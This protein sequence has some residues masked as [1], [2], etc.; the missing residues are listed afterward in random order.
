MPPPL[1]TNS[2]APTAPHPAPSGPPSPRGRRI[3]DRSAA[4]CKVQPYTPSE[5]R[6]RGPPPPTRRE[7]YAP[8]GVFPEFGA[9]GHAAA[10]T[11]EIGGASRPSSVMA[12]AMTPSPRGRLAP[13]RFLRM[14]LKRIG[15]CRRP[16]SALPGGVILLSAPRSGRPPSVSPPRSAVSAGKTAHSSTANP[17]KWHLPPIWGAG[18]ETPG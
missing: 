16:Y 8:P 3:P 10:P 9:S 13:R 2:T 4:F 11:N 7:A 12:Y 6:K 5:P 15:A 14:E 17:G 18:P 1:R